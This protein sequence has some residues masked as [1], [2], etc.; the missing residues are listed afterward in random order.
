MQRD[1]AVIHV[2]A[3]HLADRSD[4]LDWLA[5]AHLHVPLA[6]ADEVRR[7]ILPPAHRH[8]RNARIIPKSRDFH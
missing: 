2:V 3:G 6:R 5:N 1:G 8:P 4:A 7:P